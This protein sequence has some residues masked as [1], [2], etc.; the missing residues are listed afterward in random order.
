VF[1]QRIEEVNIWRLNGPSSIEQG[2][3]AKLIS[4][5]RR[6]HQPQYSPDGSQIAFSSDRTGRGSI[7]VCASDGSNPIELTQE[8][9]AIWP[10]W[11][12]SGQKLAFH[13][14]DY[15]RGRSDIHVMDAQGGFPQN[16]TGADE[17]GGGIPTWSSDEKWIYFVTDRPDEWQIWKLPVEGGPPQQLTTDGGRRALD[18]GSGDV[19]FHRKGRL[20]RMPSVGGDARLIMDKWVGQSY[21]V[22]RNH[23]VYF[24]SNREDGLVIEMLDLASEKTKRVATLGRLGLRAGLTVSP[25]G[26]W[27]LLSRID[28]SGS[29]LVLVEHFR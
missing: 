1:S 14:Y 23:L 22:W 26:Q 18:G 19:F 24:T 2:P 15:E 9:Q 8:K 27:I 4:S 13:V 5:T 10:S 7:W 3:P 16:L 21:C 29:D 12:P 6:D 28:R 20:W 11:S 17:Y 25:D